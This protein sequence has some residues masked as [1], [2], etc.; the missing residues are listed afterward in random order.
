MKIL[1]MLIATTVVICSQT[2]FAVSRNII[3]RQMK[4][5]APDQRPTVMA[6]FKVELNE[7]GFVY[8][9]FPIDCGNASGGNPV[10]MGLQSPDKGCLKLSVQYAND[11]LIGISLVNAPDMSRGSL[12]NFY[13]AI[14]NKDVARMPLSLNA[15]FGLGDSSTN[16]IGSEIVCQFEK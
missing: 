11:L 7:Y 6:E 2:S 5:L 16:G 4:T 14:Q 9:S 1:K 12:P 3:C 8:R 10:L 13:A 15:E